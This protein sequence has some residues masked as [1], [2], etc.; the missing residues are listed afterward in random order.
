VTLRSVA[1]RVLRPQAPV[2]PP[3]D[4]T[5]VGAFERDDGSPLDLWRKYRDVAKPGW[6]NFWWQTHELRAA[7]ARVTLPAEGTALL[8]DLESSST[9]PAPLD[10]FAAVLGVVAEEH[11]EV[12]RAHGGVF[13]VV[14]PAADAEAVAAAYRTSAHVMSEQLARAK[15]AVERARVLE[16]G[17]GTGYLT[18]AFTSLGADAVGIDASATGWARLQHSA[19]RAALVGDDSK[20]RLVVADGGDLP[21]EDASFD[22]IVSVSV[23]EHLVDLPGVL[24][25]TARVLRPGG[26]A[27]HGVHPWYCATGGHSLCSTD[28]PWGHARL[29]PA[30]FERYVRELRPYEADEAIASYRTDFQQPRRTFAGLRTA[31][32]DAG[33]DIRVWNEARRDPPHVAILDRVLLDDCR[34]HAPEAT[35]DDLLRGAIEVLLQRR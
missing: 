34:R 13:E 23:L 7:A 22:A 8:A 20:D 25:E 32:E 14:R 4:L 16:L 28:A 2:G 5:V 12:V 11:P 17:A 29:A 10:E 9:L 6:Q 15:I 18:Y 31:I 1:R 27:Y 24:A 30:E 26:V 35:V 33:F 19:V 21:F 3:I